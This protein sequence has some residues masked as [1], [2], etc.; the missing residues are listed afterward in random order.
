ML[1]QQC[2][3]SFVFYRYIIKI[4]VWMDWNFSRARTSHEKQGL[5]PV[6]THPLYA[7]DW[8]VHQKYNPLFSRVSLY[9]TRCEQQTSNQSPRPSIHATDWKPDVHCF[10][11]DESTTRTPSSF[12][13]ILARDSTHCHLFYLYSPFITEILRG[14]WLSARNMSWKRSA[15]GEQRRTLAVSLEI[16]DR[17]AQ[18]LQTEWRRQK[19]KA[20]WR[21][22][23]NA[24]I[25][26]AHCHFFGDA[27]WLYKRRCDKGMSHCHR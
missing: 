2:A 6:L 7:A 10:Q 3:R 25:Q 18:L 26:N 19:K 23:I 21:R 5:K 27:V 17:N 22:S 9:F 12:G 8:S 15:E 20:V 1:L 4:I 11:A 13:V 16:T 14:F 24:A